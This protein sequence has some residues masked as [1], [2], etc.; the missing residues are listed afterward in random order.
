M[1]SKNLIELFH[2]P[3]TEQDAVGKGC[4][5]VDAFACVP[6]GRKTMRLECVLLTCAGRT[7]CRET[8]VGW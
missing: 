8:T 3:G 7:W 4:S 5:N 2:G 6:L 1:N